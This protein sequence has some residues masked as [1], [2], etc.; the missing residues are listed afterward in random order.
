MPWGLLFG[1]QRRGVRW[2]A[3]T[4]ALLAALASASAAQAAPAL[5]WSAPKGNSADRLATA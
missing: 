2:L 5:Y 1:E 3:V 4:L